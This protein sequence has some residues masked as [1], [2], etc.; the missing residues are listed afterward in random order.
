MNSAL[1]AYLRDAGARPF[2]WGACDCCSWTCDWV[3]QV[4][5]VDPAAAWRGQCASE[6]DA[7][8]IVARG[9]GVLALA[10]A[11]CA[12]AGLVP[13]GDPLPGDVGVVLTPQGAT[14][15]IRTRIGWACK[16]T[17]GLAVGPYPRLAAWRVECLR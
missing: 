12:A 13:T 9:G 15:A 4:A 17:D 16:T 2:A 10:Q 8:R 11:G 7:R 5:G 6:H 3:L 1:A 14:M